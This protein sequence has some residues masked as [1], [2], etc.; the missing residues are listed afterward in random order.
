[1]FGT[2][3]AD[4]QWRSPWTTKGYELTGNL[5]PGVPKKR[6]PWFESDEQYEA[7]LNTVAAD[8]G[9]Q[10]ITATSIGVEHLEEDDRRNL[11]SRCAL[12][13][14][15]QLVSAT[16]ARLDAAALFSRDAAFEKEFVWQVSG[17][18]R[19]RVGQQLQ[20][21]SRL[22]PPAA[23]NQL[24]REV[25]EWCLDTE[26]DQDKSAGGIK[27]PAT[28]ARED[29]IHLLL[30]INGDQERQDSP[31][32][33]ESWPPTAE[34]LEQ[35]NAAMTDDDELVL[36]QLQK[37][38]LSE[39]A[40]MQTNAIT[41]PDIVLG[42][43]YDT[44]FKGWPKVAPHDLIGDTPEDAFFAAATVT[45]RE[46]IKLG[47]HLWERTKNGDVVFTKTSVEG[48]I[49][50]DV[51]ALMQESASL[52]VKDYRKRLER[53]RKKGYLAH[54]RYT[55]TERPLLEIG[56]DEFIA[57][58]PTWVLDRFCGSQLYWQTFFDFGTEKD[59]RGEQFSQCMNYV[60]EATVAYLFRRVMRRAGG[61]IVLITEE[62]MQQAWTSGGKTPSVCDW[63]L[64]SGKN[65]LLVDAT[66]H[67][68]DEKAAQGFAEV[69]EYRADVEDTFVNK[70]FQQLK[71]TIEHLA[72]NGW[73]GCQFDNET[74]YVPLVVVPNAGI[75]ATVF[76]DIDIKLRSHPV[77]G[78]LGKNVTSP[79]IL[80]YHELQVFEGLCEHRFPRTF[81][82]VLARWR[83]QCTASMPIRPQTFL[84]LQGM[85]RPMG[86]YPTTARSML[87]KRLEQE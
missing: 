34:E 68:L 82:D 83:S 30:A 59:P 44:W 67:W 27:E 2:V 35:F 73:D 46:C 24:I 10:C 36:Q 18:L 13:P 50:P 39:F 37:Q 79:G 12:Q 11:L 1:V 52:P 6:P 7:F 55:F 29:F 32:F 69:D 21:G 72:G 62:Q 47:L 57:L 58:R 45:L 81:V 40:R 33:F 8:L 75:P 49:D 15:L 43:T 85:D 19:Q 65:C 9:P 78:Q 3:L 70:K 87:M 77:L 25:I 22:M 56:T 16:Y 26:T 51:L 38:M 80:V 84:E 4:W 86:K 71:S 14:T 60:F 54:R 53:E 17:D 20:K 64:V 66:N 5:P 61:Q 48:S 63:V 74:V 28:L 41:V 42:D 23:M 76:A 31:E